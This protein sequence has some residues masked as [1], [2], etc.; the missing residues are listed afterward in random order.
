MPFLLHALFQ[1]KNKNQLSGSAQLQAVRQS[2]GPRQVLTHPTSKGISFF[3]LKR[4][5]QRVCLASDSTIGLESSGWMVHRLGGQVALMQV[6]ISRSL[7]SSSCSSSGSSGSS[8]SSSHA[9]K[10]NTD[11][12][13]E[14]R[15]AALKCEPRI[16]ILGKQRGHDTTFLL[17]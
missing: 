2:I 17:S 10:L 9:V 3:Y 4:H 1:A 16:N 8:S 5:P 15:T 6:R 11:R 13:S 14:R 12:N 7:C